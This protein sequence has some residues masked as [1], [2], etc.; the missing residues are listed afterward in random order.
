MNRKFGKFEAGIWNNKS[1]IK[2]NGPLS[3]FKAVP[4]LSDNVCIFGVENGIT[5]AV[6]GIP[7]DFDLVMFDNNKAY[8]L[9]Q[10]EGDV[11]IALEPVEIGDLSLHEDLDVIMFAV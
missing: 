8:K 4:G 3:L 7:V 11:F 2:Y 1:L 5:T 6:G 9:E 10:F